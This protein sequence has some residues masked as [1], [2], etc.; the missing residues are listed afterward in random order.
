MFFLNSNIGYI[1]LDNVQYETT[2]EVSPYTY[3]VAI[4]PMSWRRVGK[5][6]IEVFDPYV[7]ATVDTLDMRNIFINGKQTDD[8]EKIVKIIEFD[9][10]NQDGFSSGR[11]KV[12][13]VYI[14]GKSVL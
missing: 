2:D 4:G 1:S 7:S 3:L 9:D 10:V 13:H 12:N 5:E 11:G 6:D 14:D 8:V